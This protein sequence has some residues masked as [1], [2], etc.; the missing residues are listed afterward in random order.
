[1]PNNAPSPNRTRTLQINS[2]ALDQLSYMGYSLKHN[3]CKTYLFQINFCENFRVPQSPVRSNVHS[4]QGTTGTRVRT[5]TGEFVSF[6]PFMSHWDV[7]CMSTAGDTS[8][9]GTPLCVHTQN[10]DKFTIVKD[11]YVSFYNSKVAGPRPQAQKG[12]GS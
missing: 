8:T 12:V 10:C 2:P 4:M 5:S 7:S 11:Y 6:F 1:M 9:S 3:I